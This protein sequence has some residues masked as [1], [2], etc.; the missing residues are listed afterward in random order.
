MP[1]STA[2]Q[3]SDAKHHATT[4]PAPIDL[5][6]P[7]PPSIFLYQKPLGPSARCSHGAFGLALTSTFQLCFFCSHLARCPSVSSLPRLHYSAVPLHYCTTTHSSSTLVTS[8]IPGVEGPSNFSRPVSTVALPSSPAD[9][10]TR[11]KTAESTRGKEH[12]VHSQNPCRRATNIQT[13]LAPKS[14]ISPTSPLLRTA[15]HR[16]QLIPRHRPAR[17]PPRPIQRSG[18]FLSDCLSAAEKTQ[19]RPLRVSRIGIARCWC[20]TT[21]TT[22]TSE[23]ERIG[24]FS[25]AQLPDTSSAWPSIGSTVTFLTRYQSII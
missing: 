22:L 2:R 7:K 3:P 13:T 10:G 6:R 23:T 24:S 8:W 21:K 16:R 9:Y 20:I 17:K 14:S 12:R 25:P 15:H 11:P 19:L 18:V 5:R 4:E 1:L